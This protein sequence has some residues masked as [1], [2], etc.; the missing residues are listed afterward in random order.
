MKELANPRNGWFTVYDLRF[1]TCDRTINSHSFSANAEWARL[2]KNCTKAVVSFLANAT[3]NG[4]IIAN[5]NKLKVGLTSILLDFY[6]D[7]IALH[8]FHMASGTVLA[9][10]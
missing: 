3:T 10:A 2:R 8:F 1:L 9:L 6:R 4:A 5:E 7:C